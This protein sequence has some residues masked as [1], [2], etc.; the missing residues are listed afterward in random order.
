MAHEIL[1]Q[2][3]FQ[4]VEPFMRA[5]CLFLAKPYAA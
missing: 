4:D 3:S 2:S 1:G 5:A